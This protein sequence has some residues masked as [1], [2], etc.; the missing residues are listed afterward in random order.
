MSAGLAL[1]GL[2]GMDVDPLALAKS[3]QAAEHHRKDRHRDD[4]SD[5][6]PGHA[7][8]GLLVARLFPQAVMSRQAR[9]A[10]S[11]R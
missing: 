9:I 8:E 6:R 4:R 5:E 10:N 3:G 2:Y 7:D 11:S 1:A